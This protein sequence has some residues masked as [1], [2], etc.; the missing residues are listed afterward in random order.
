MQKSIACAA[1]VA[2]GALV[3]SASHAEPASKH[4]VGYG[5][6]PAIVSEGAWQ[7]I[8]AQK[9]K[10]A[11]GKGLAITVSLECGLYTNNVAK[12]KGL[13]K[14]DNK[15]SV[16]VRVL[17]DGEE[18]AAPGAVT[19]CSRN[20]KTS[21]L[22]AGIF[23]RDSS[24]EN[25]SCFFLEEI[26]TSEPPDG[27][28]DETIVKFDPSCLTPEE[29]ELLEDTTSA[30]AFS[31]YYD[32]TSPGVHT[33]TVEAMIDEATGVEGDATALEDQG[34]KATLGNGSLL[35][36][37]IRLIKGSNGETLEF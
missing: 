23:S 37:E 1:A 29:M 21:A 14:T 3:A 31:F 11:N 32:D 7:P 25:D 16:Q 10:T 36:E 12:S 8:L 20:T 33:V 27:I 30:H 9:I 2:L 24:V 15:A 19:F 28:P 34:A 5:E 26:D 13:A 22:F 35:I 17:V 4:A 6:A 18:V